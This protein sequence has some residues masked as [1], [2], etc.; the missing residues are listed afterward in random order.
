MSKDTSKFFG[1]PFFSGSVSRGRL[2]LASLSCCLDQSLHSN[3]LKVSFS[4]V[5]ANK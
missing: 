2:L 5:R 3:P 1:V 4:R